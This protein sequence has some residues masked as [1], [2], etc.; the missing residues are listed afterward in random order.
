M[1]FTL[2]SINHILTVITVTAFLYSRRD[3]FK[4]I[5][6]SDLVPGKLENNVHN[7]FGK[8]EHQVNHLLH[9]NRHKVLG[10]EYQ[11]YDFESTDFDELLRVKQEAQ[12]IR[13]RYTANEYN[14]LKTKQDNTINGINHRF[15]NTSF[16]IALVSFFLLIL[17]AGF[18][19][20]DFAEM[21][22]FLTSYNI[23]NIIILGFIYNKLRKVKNTRVI[24]YFLISILISYF[25]P[26][27]IFH[28]E[29]I[30]LYNNLKDTPWAI[31]LI[32]LMDNDNAYS[33]TL[34]TSLVILLSPW[35]I[36]FLQFLFV[37]LFTSRK[38]A[39]HEKP[40]LEQLKNLAGYILTKQ[41]LRLAPAPEHSP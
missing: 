17:A 30:A 6:D 15:S 7:L 13:D 5:L 1:R 14:I 24:V 32:H 12:R 8:I 29:A 4:D 16:F 2:E 3:F 19:H 28:K 35:I 10:I 21:E 20:V 40:C 22:I 23:T 25:I 31:S 34:F 27:I 33:F 39:K 37:F 18:Q 9:E 36:G 41:A 11:V 38:L 26:L